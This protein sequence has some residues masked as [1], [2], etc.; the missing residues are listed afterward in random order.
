MKQILLTTIILSILCGCNNQVNKDNSIETN[1]K[2]E[3]TE[4]DSIENEWKYQ[5][6][7]RN[8]ID[9]L[10]LDV[11]STP[12]LEFID[13]YPKLD[14]VSGFD[15]D[16]KYTSNGYGI[17]TNLILVGLLRKKGFKSINWDVPPCRLGSRT[18]SVSFYLE[19]EKCECEVSKIFYE[20][21]QEEWFKVNERIK[22]KK[23]AGNNEKEKVE[24][25]I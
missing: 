9:S 20:T 13:L 16:N 5:E 4:S 22:C 3:S 19:N 21:D 10:L 25:C 7:K 12:N 14:S 23:P 1:G 18:F 17:D 15:Q 11:C 6:V 8:Y 2:P 24:S